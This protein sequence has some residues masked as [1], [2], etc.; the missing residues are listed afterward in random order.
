M[1]LLFLFSYFP[2]YVRGGAEY[3]G[4][5]LV[6]ELSKKHNVTIL[7]PNYS[8]YENKVFYINQLRVIAF[9]SIRFFLVKN[10]NKEQPNYNRN[11]SKEKRN[12]YFKMCVFYII[13]LIE[14]KLIIKKHLKNNS[15]DI[16]HANNFESGL[17]LL[18]LNFSKRVIHLRDFS[19][20]CMNKGFYNSNKNINCYKC[21]Y[22]NKKDCFEKD[23][24]LKRFFISIFQKNLIRKMKKEKIFYIAIS[25]Y[26][27]NVFQERIPG[28][29]IARVYNPL[30]KN[31][32]LISDYD[33][34]KIK[35][36]LGIEK[37]KKVVLFVGTFSKKKG[38]D[39]FT[40]L[41]RNNP[42]YYFLV[43]GKVVDPNFD[44][45]QNLKF[46]GNKK[47]SDMKYYYGIANVVL[48]PSL[49][50]E[51]FGRV[52]VESLFFKKHVIAFPK[53]GMTELIDEGING[54]IVKDEKEMNDK[55]VYL[56]NENFFIHNYELEKYSPD[57]IANEVTKAYKEFFD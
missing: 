8:N 3:S 30:E 17:A 29:N 39:V 31:Y 48:V 9:K 22:K 27:K 15:Y 41:A 55:L 2:P 37:E 38:S 42:S 56:L 6:E 18:F 44:N 21:T 53:G 47:N 45:P 19:Y 7:T 35:E 5:I 50:E 25:E 13:S 24:I 20:F 11:T 28:I 40:N 1:N 10:L 46:L 16:I 34:D 12:S 43:C 57:N 32:T 26:L 52:V 54:F 33:K 14:F 49:W 51:P 36:E 23:G 4:K